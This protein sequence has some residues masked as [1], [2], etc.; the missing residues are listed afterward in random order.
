M[1]LPPQVGKG[2]RVLCI[3]PC[4][5]SESWPTVALEGIT[6]PVTGTK[7]KPIMDLELKGGCDGCEVVA[8]FLL[9]IEPFL[10]SLQMPLCLLQCAQSIFEVLEALKDILS[11]LTSLPPDLGELTSAMTKA[12]AKCTQCFTGWSV[13]AF[14]RLLRDIIDL[15]VALLK[16]VQDVLTKLITLNLQVAGLMADPEIEIQKTG[17]C[18]LGLLNAQKEDLFARIDVLGSMLEALGFLFQFVGVSGISDI[19]VSLKSLSP[20]MGL[21]TLVAQLQSII[22]LLGEPGKD[23]GIRQPVD[24]YAK[25]P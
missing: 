8:D 13:G 17:E 21:D 4:P 16:C 10:I 7:V 25:M 14:C 18:L 1:S 19:T 3:N 11:D 2:A 5:P 23:N 20:L 15:I 6:L 24:I 12:A 22:N 9:M